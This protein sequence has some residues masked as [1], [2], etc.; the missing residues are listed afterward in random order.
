MVLDTS[1]I[2]AILFNEEDAKSYPAAITEADSCRVSATTFVEVAIVVEAQTKN[3]GS[4]QR[5]GQQAVVRQGQQ[6]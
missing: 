5:Q 1:A 4:R 3:S 6:A 2:V